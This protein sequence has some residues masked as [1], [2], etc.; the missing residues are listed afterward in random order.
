MALTPQYYLHRSPGPAQDRELRKRLSSIGRE[1]VPDLLDHLL[2][3]D[4]CVALLRLVL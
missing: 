3:D 1:V 4:L 2:I